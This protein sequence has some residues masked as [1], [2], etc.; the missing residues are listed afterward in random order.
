MKTHRLRRYFHQELGPWGSDEQHD[1]LQLINIF[2]EQHK[3]KKCRDGNGREAAE[4][5]L[6]EVCLNK[7]RNE[8]FNIYCKIRNLK[9]AKNLIIYINKTNNTQAVRHDRIL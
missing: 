9:Q 4:I 5:K 3:G 6:N 8:Y 1:K 7:L 2:K